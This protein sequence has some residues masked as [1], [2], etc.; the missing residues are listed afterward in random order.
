[1]IAAAGP[2]QLAKLRKRSRNMSRKSKKPLDSVGVIADCMPKGAKLDQRE[3]FNCSVR[4]IDNGYILSK[5][6]SDGNTY[7]HSE[8]FHKDR[9]DLGMVGPDRIGPG[10][11]QMRDAVRI[12]K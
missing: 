2:L 1:V 6:H 4:R 11:E 9:P 10:N 3:D 7:H 5:S 8:E 12:L